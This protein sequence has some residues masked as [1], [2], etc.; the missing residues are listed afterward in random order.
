MTAWVLARL[1][2]GPSAALRKLSLPETD[3]CVNLA[4]RYAGSALDRPWLAPVSRLGPGLALIAPSS[5]TVGVEAVQL[6][7]LP[8]A[9]ALLP[10]EPP[11]N[12]NGLPTPTLAVTGVLPL[13]AMKFSLLDDPDS[14][15]LSSSASTV[16]VPWLVDELTMK[17]AFEVPRCRE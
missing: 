14:D 5:V 1:E 16:P 11:T 15:G 2:P 10:F 17:D 7:W 6:A 13:G 12:C 9:K 8:P 4:A 3:R